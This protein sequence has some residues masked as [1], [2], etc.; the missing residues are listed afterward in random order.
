MYQHAAKFRW[1]TWGQ[2]RQVIL[3]DV[4]EL[5]DHLNLPEYARLD[6]GHPGDPTMLSGKWRK[7][8]RKIQGF[9]GF[10]VPKGSGNVAL[11]ASMVVYLFTPNLD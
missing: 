9:H 10:P 3:E 2:N 6:T 4:K 1:T 7:N 5:E 8:H 11:S